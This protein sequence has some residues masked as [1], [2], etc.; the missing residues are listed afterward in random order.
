MNYLL[1]E[2]T[3]SLEKLKGQLLV[4]GKLSFTTLS[5]PL[6][7]IVDSLTQ[8][9]TFTGLTQNNNW[10]QCDFA[11]NFFIFNS[12][13]LFPNQNYS[14]FQARGWLLDYICSKIQGNF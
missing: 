5:C 13:K 7:H 2:N 10:I 8:L 14:P 4:S 1:Q 11:S 6:V 3:T 12:L 9:I